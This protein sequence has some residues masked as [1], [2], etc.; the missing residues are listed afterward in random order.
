MSHEVSGGF[1]R[2]RGGRIVIRIGRPSGC[3]RK[4]E[5]DVR[6]AHRAVTCVCVLVACSCMQGGLVVGGRGTGTGTVTYQIRFACG[7]G[8]ASGGME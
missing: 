5:T 8:R 7:F 1:E 2:G 3:L 4:A 6:A